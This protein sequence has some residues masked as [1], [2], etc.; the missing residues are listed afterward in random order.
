MLGRDGPA[1][2]LCVPQLLQVSVVGLFCPVVGLFRPVVGLFCKLAGLCS[3]SLLPFSRS[4]LPFIRSLSRSLL[5]VV[6]FSRTACCHCVCVCVCVLKFDIFNQY[7][8]FTHVHTQF[9]DFKS[10]R[11]YFSNCHLAS[12]PACSRRHAPAWYHP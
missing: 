8:Y 4:L 2:G 11:L 10:L 3:R 5:T 7:F 9:T 6:T 1:S 12:P